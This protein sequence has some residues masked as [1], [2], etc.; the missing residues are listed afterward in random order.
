MED[1]SGKPVLEGFFKGPQQDAEDPSENPGIAEDFGFQE[2]IDIAIEVDGAAVIE[3]ERW[4]SEAEV[5]GAD[6]AMLK[7]KGSFSGSDGTIAQA[8]RDSVENRGKEAE[9]WD[10]P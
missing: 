7:S 8:G 6:L 2:G 5:F 1:G 10:A 4:G 3:A 9:D